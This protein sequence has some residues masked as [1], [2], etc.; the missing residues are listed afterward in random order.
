M[1][2]VVYDQGQGLVRW[3]GTDPNTSKVTFGLPPRHP[4]EDDVEELAERVVTVRPATS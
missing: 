3:L 1:Q 4:G 2:M